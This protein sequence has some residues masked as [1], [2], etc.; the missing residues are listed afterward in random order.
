MTPSGVD[1]AD[2]PAVTDARRLYRVG[3]VFA[4]LGGAVMLAAAS[5]ALSRI[6]LEP[7]ADGLTAACDRLLSS[8][9][10]TAAAVLGLAILGIVIIARTALTA[11]RIG[12]RSARAIATLRASSS[13]P[14]A[15]VLDDDSINAFC[16]G[17]LRPR[18]YVTRGAVRALEREALEAVIAHE[19]HHAAR[20]DPLRILIAR[21]A[22]DGLFFL[23]VLRRIAERYAD[24]AELDA[25]KAAVCAT[26]DPS[27]LASALLTFDERTGTSGGGVA[28]ER[29]DSL[30]GMPPASRASL[31]G[32]A[33]TLVSV[34]ATVVLAMTA[35]GLAAASSVVMP[36]MALHGLA[37]L[38]LVAVPVGLP[39]LARAWRRARAAGVHPA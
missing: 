19:T 4:G 2:W 26:G 32:V 38:A 31:A 13:V 8:A 1:C 34:A 16:A 23:P 10:F 39:A 29:V 37:L 35:A 30:C 12:H 17:L 9:D 28:R 3:V 5:V 20:R 25:D 14:G 22:A 36:A 27:A 21:A 11:V 15:H 7:P 24:L 33:V 18:V 6:R